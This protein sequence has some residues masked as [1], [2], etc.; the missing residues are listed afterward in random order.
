MKRILL[1]LMA[2]VLVLSLA[3]CGGNDKEPAES[4]NATSAP[5][6]ENS[7]APDTNSDKADDTTSS[8]PSSDNP[9][10]GD[11]DF[12][13][14][15]AGSATTDTVWGKQDEATKQALIAEGKKDGVD[16]SFGAD[17]SMTIVDPKN[18][19][20][21]IQKP[22]GTWSI[23]SEDGTEGQYGGEWPE[24]EFTKLVPKPDLELI[25]ATSNDQEF[26]VLFEKA[27]I[28]Q[29]KE[30]AEKIK[31]A[32]FTLEAETADST[33]MGIQVFTYQAKNSAGYF[34]TVSYAMGTS[35]LTIEK[36]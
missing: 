31:G 19:D 23:K 18:G 12:S 20:T 34:V 2:I 21:I 29:V 9:I 32:G 30:Y 24:N 13:A 27:T 6:G 17:G 35:G 25:A 4:G 7:A 8:Q 16:V 3:A 28:E 22:D 14:I 33:S 26:A 36:A 5:A 10:V 11:I 1:F 15:L